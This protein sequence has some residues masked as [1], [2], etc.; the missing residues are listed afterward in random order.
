MR[1]QPI[2]ML[3]TNLNE[4]AEYAEREPVFLT[5]NG[6]ENLVILSHVQYNNMKEEFELYDM[7]QRSIHE[8]D[9]TT[10]RTSA[11]EV[12][13]EMERILK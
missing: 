11:D 1:I 2:S 10:E 6:K 7:L 8:Y 12:F 9:T 4:I 13:S 5:K 3:R